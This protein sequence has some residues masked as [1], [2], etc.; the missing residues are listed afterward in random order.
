MKQVS[1]FLAVVLIVILL[2]GCSFV[3][4][5]TSDEIALLN[6]PPEHVK[7]KINKLLPVTIEWYSKT[8]KEL[9]EKGRQ[10][11][12]S[13]MH[14]ARISG[15]AKPDKV[16]VII[17]ND[18]PMPK[19][20]NLQKEAIK[21]GF[22]SRFEGARMM[23]KAI[24]IKPEHSNNSVILSHELVHLA[25]HDKMGRE[26]FI[27]RYLIELEILGY[28]RSLLELEAYEKQAEIQKYP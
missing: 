5:P 27:K 7:N 15:V 4:K 1:K 13:E 25:Q 2:T 10:L 23:G 22:G 24:L 12:K 11:T 19:D 8:E 17:T 16:R 3:K 18:F 20:E 6:N 21:Y 9:L 14:I 28:S 26:A